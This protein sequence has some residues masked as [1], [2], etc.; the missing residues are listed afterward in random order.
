[1][2]C[3]DADDDDDDDADN[4]D[5]DDNADADEEAYKKSLIGSIEDPARQSHHSCEAPVAFSS[6]I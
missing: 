3:V 5:D 1:M 6:H 2:D 4:D